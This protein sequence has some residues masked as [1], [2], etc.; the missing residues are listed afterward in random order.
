[1]K[2]L[3]PRVVSEA[4][5]GITIGAI[6]TSAAC[7]PKSGVQPGAPVLTTLTIVE[8]SGTK[9]NIDAM[10]AA[11]DPAITNGG[12]CDPTATPVCQLASKTF[13]HCDAKMMDD[14]SIL[15]ESP[16]SMG[17]ATCTYDTASTVIAVF[18]RLLDTGPLAPTS[19]AGT[20]P[21][22]VVQ[23]MVTP[24]S[25]VTVTAD[26]AAT[27][28]DGL[29][30][31]AVF[32]YPTGPNITFAADPA[33]PGGSDI[34]L[35]LLPDKIRAKDHKTPFTGMGLLNAG[36]LTFS[37]AQAAPPDDA[38]TDAPSPDDGGADGGGSSDG[39]VDL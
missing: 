37:T 19:D 22:N 13:C 34:T 30:Y 35:T 18:D 21:T 14:P 38:G 29:I 9:T 25:T 20:L 36:V 12:D 5:A 15:P 2:R 6:V 4:L 3:F 33:F 16:V 24:T 23:V 7:D 26:Y 31:P 32:G 17:L 27:G 8:P 28:I 10:T 11:C 39:G 1:M